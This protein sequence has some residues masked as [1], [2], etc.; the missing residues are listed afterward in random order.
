MNSMPY[1][2][3]SSNWL[4]GGGSGS[5]NLL[6]WWKF[7]SGSE[8]WFQGAS[9]YKTSQ[10]LTFRVVYVTRLIVPVLHSR[11]NIFEKKK[12]QRVNLC[13][14]L[15]KPQSGDNPTSML[16]PRFLSQVLKRPIVSLSHLSRKPAQMPPPALPDTRGD[17]IAGE[18]GSSEQEWGV[19]NVLQGPPWRTSV[20][21]VRW[22][23]AL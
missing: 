2:T 13:P 21:P 18:A 23:G 10:V 16:W 22:R 14:T 17:W 7:L 12:H 6:G 4:G 11:F 15:N 5:R 9:V 19:V 8:R 3:S 1:W 20:L